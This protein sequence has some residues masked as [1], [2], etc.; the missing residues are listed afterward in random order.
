MRLTIGIAACLAGFWRDTRTYVRL[1]LSATFLAGGERLAFRRMRI[2]S[3]SDGSLVTNLPVDP[4]DDQLTSAGVRQVLRT[5]V[6]G[7]FLRV[8]DAGW[9]AGIA[10][11]V[12]PPAIRPLVNDAVLFLCHGDTLAPAG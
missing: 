6:D 2:I 7:F 3:W 9:T 1:G 4:L 10:P 12:C 8:M 11:F 5:G